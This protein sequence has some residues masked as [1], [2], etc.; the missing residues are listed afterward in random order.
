MNSIWSILDKLSHRMKQLGA[1]FLMG[2]VAVTCCDVVGRF[3]GSPIF[4]SE[5]IVTFLLCLVVAFSLPFSHQEKIHVGVEILVR[6]LPPKT[7]KIVK[8]CTD[9]AT[10]ALMV[11]ITV[12]M[13]AYARTTQLSGEVSMN[14][15]LPEYWVIY[16]LAACFCALSFFIL[17]DIVL[18]FKKSKGNA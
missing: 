5:E 8:L 6:L 18:F 10:L 15:E 17:R 3:F 14:L 7:R 12:M 2:M 16:A 11:T 13:F 4:G 9:I 1:F